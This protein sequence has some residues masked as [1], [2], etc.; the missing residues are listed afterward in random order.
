MNHEL[1]WWNFFC[2]K[3]AQ[4]IRKSNGSRPLNFLWNYDALCV[5]W[6]CVCT[7]YTP[8]APSFNLLNHKLPTKRWNWSD[9]SLILL[10]VLG[11]SESHS[12]FSFS[13][14]CFLATLAHQ[15]PASWLTSPRKKKRK[16]NLSIHK[17]KVWCHAFFSAELI[18][19]WCTARF[20]LI[21]VI[22]AT[23]KNRVAILCVGCEHE[24]LSIESKA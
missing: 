20:L 1:V 3:V 24:C 18:F 19:H 2:P 14:V 16:K 21:H 13:G 22:S 8:S 4:E 10:S 17:K 9:W 6:W 15:P 7:C 5:C 11:N 23:P 12:F